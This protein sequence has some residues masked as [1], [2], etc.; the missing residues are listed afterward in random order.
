MALNKYTS[1]EYETN[2]IVFHNESFTVSGISYYQDIVKNIDYNCE[3]HMISEINNPF[4]K[5]AI[6]IYY[7]ECKIGYV[8]KNYKHKMKQYITNN[9]KMKIIN[10]KKIRNNNKNI[11]GIRI[12]HESLFETNMINDSIFGD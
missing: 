12:I 11:I 3:L 4:D 9:N 2:K 1:N 7:N 5:E 10:I 6:A 8:P